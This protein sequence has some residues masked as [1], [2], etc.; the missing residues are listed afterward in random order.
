MRQREYHC[1]VAGLPEIRLEGSSLR[2]SPRAF[3]DALH[4][5]LHPEDFEMA[6]LLLLRYDHPNLVRFLEGKDLLH[7]GIARFGAK[8]YS[9][10]K[11]I[12][13]AIVPEEDILPPYMSEVLRHYTRPDHPVQH[14]ECRRRLDDG[15]FNW[16]TEKGTGFIRAYTE[17]E[18][19]LSNM[20]TYLANNRSG[21]TRPGEG[22]APHGSHA[23]HLQETAGRNP[24]RDPGFAYYD[25]ILAIEE[26]HRLA[27]AE[28]RYDRLRWN[29]IETLTLF[30]DFTA[31][32]VLAYLQKLL[33]AS[34][35]AGMA[36][37]TGSKR[38]KEAMDATLGDALKQAEHV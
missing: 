27:D 21:A 17:F 33:I 8:E 37:E 4:N 5:E 36:A 23:R 20:L 11:E 10:Q 18:Y 13:E 14:V 19:N 2:T 30:E 1:F 6:E 35:W 12:F 25:E 29:V 15:Y 3:I 26:N 7:E 9:R 22:I 31:D 38:L 28:I 16:V 34:R 32:A 24:V